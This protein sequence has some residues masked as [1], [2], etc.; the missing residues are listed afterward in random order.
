M[1]TYNSLPAH[2]AT[3]VELELKQN[4][5]TALQADSFLVRTSIT[6]ADSS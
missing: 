4:Y 1:Q 5:I 6:G 3:P 2:Q